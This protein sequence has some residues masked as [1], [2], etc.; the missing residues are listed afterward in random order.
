MSRREP[1]PMTPRAVTARLRVILLILL[2]YGALLALAPASMFER[3]VVLTP[4]VLAAPTAWLAYILQRAAA[5]SREL[6]DWRLQYATLNEA[7]REIALWGPEDIETRVVADAR[8]QTAYL[9][10]RAA[11]LGLSQVLLSA[12]FELR[13]ALSVLLDNPA[14]R[15]G[16]MEG[17]VTELAEA[18]RGELADVRRIYH[19]LADLI[20]AR[21]EV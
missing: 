19:H 20:E 18:I 21:Q 3:L 10:V 15:E 1:K 11:D 2:V 17:A 4:L 12:L 9:L 8:R 13:E 5:F 7:L 6:R 14:L 16:D